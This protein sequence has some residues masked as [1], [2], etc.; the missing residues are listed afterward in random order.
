MPATAAPSW[1]RR[2]ASAACRSTFCPASA[3]S[4]LTALGVVS[5]IHHADGIVGDLGGGSLELVDVRGTRVK[6]GVTLPLGV[7]ALQDVSGKSIKKAEKIVAD[8]FARSADQTSRGANLL[9][10]RRH[11]AR[12]RAP[13]HVADRL[14]AACDA[15]LRDPGA[16]SGRVLP[17]GASRRSGN[18]VAYRGGGQAAARAAALCGASARAVAGEDARQERGHFGARRARGPAL[19][20][21]RRRGAPEGPAHRG[22]ARAQSAAL[23]FAAARGGTGRM[24]RPVHGFLGP[25]R[26]ARKRSG[27]AMPPA[28]SPTSDGA[29]IPIIAASSRSTS[30]RMAGSPASTIPAGH[31]SL[32]RCSSAMSACC[33]TRNCRRACASLPRP[34]CSIVRACS[35]RRCASPIW[36]PPQCRACCRA[37]RCKREQ[38]PP[39]PAPEAGNCRRLPASG[40]SIGCANSRA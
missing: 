2:S 25:R 8:A 23:A 28:C 10:G 3:K 22:G 31:F 27:C 29:R 11:L 32:W 36:S 20:V 14:S 9:C 1:R 38:G 15:W 40:C 35:A 34:A 30:S 26:N 21:A 12:A 33:T 39:G 17:P 37:R 4:Q 18:A 24:D 13:A 19:F 7:L 16:G 5:G 6:T